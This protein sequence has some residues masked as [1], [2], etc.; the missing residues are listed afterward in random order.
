[1]SEGTELLL[2]SSS[3]GS[4]VGSQLAVIDAKYCS[5][6]RTTLVLKKHNQWNLRRSF[7]YTITDR[8]G[9]TLF[10]VTSSSVLS[11]HGKRT[12]L[13]A[14]SQP[15]VTMARQ[16]VLALT[17]TWDVF[18]GA[19]TNTS[20]SSKLAEVAEQWRVASIGDVE[21]VV[22]QVEKESCFSS[23]AAFA[24]GGLLGAPKYVLHI[25]PGV[26]AAFVV[27]LAVLFDFVANRSPY[28]HAG[29]GP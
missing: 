3:R 12:L 29:G 2:S 4:H 24:R 27:V 23:A 18:K 13:D 22:A 14:D 1:M 21:L 19:D 9:R 20:P 7:D 6:Q 11:T 8:H 17:H 5:P 16:H 26:D 10:T 28:G 25:E 15:L